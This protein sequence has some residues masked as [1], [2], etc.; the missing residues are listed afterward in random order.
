MDN[1]VFKKRHDKVFLKHEDL[2]KML[3]QLPQTQ[4]L[5][6]DRYGMSVFEEV[7]C[8]VIVGLGIGLVTL[9]FYVLIVGVK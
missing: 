4:E 2:H 6:S 1:I 7:L 3:S 8:W 9:A 5:D